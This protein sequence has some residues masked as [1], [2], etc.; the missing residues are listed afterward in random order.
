M[1]PAEIRSEFEKAV[2]RL[3]TL[4]K[5]LEATETSEGTP[6]ALTKKLEKIS[7]A[8]ADLVR[9][10]KDCSHASGQN[11]ETNPF[12]FRLVQELQSGRAISRAKQRRPEP[13]DGEQYPTQ[14]IENI[15]EL[16]RAA[17]ESIHLIKPKRGNSTDRTKAQKLKA[18][19]GKNFI[20]LYLQHFDCQYPNVSPTGW[21][22]DVYEKGLSVLELGAN[23]PVAALRDAV[24][25][26][27]STVQ[28]EKF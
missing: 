9:A 19:F 11:L 16:Q 25:I 21:I 4:L 14:L 27:K 7:K 17:D 12:D 23:D 20:H 5:R 24:Q 15:K 3:A 26:H 8:S 2:M 18:T 28:I 1:T 10:L 13:N 6:A 22:I